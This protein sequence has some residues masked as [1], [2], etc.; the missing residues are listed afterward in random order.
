MTEYALYK[1][2]EIIG[3]GTA[4]ELAEKLGIK[5]ETIR[6]YATPSQKKRVA[7]AADPENQMIAVKIDEK[8]EENADE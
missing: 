3:I 1:G 2:D 7:A 4:K 6:W 5:P 8:D